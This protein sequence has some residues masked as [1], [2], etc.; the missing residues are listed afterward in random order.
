MS[1][2]EVLERYTKEILKGVAWQKKPKDR[3][4]GPPIPEGPAVPFEKAEAQSRVAKAS[5]T[6]KDGGK[7]FGA[8][9]QIRIIAANPGVDLVHD[10]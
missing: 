7:K 4:L 2:E 9:D 1:S 10:E 5:A 8:H 3:K 6:K